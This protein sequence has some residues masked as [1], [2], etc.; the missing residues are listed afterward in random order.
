MFMKK[1]SLLIACMAFV[2]L[3]M[4]QLVPFD[5]L[6]LGQTPPGNE[7]KIFKLEVT[8]GKF[9][10]ERIAISKDGSEIY[11][12]EVKGYYPN[13]GEKTRYYKYTNN[14][15]SGSVVLFE[16]FSGPALSVTDDTLF[17]EREFKMYYSV[18]KNSGWS[19]PEVF[20]SAIDSAHYLQVT[21]K[22][23]YYA[24][25]RSK[26]SVG[27]SDWSKIQITGK[28]TIAVSLGFPV[29]RVVD[30]LDF[31]VAKDESYMITCP[32]GPIGISYPEKEEGKWS[33]MRYLNEKINFGIGGWGTY[34]TADNKY[35]FYTT[36][37]KMDY[38]DTYIYWVSMGNIVDSLKHTNRPPY[39]KNKPRVQSATVG[40]NFIYTLPVDAFCDDDGTIITQ[41]ALLIDGNPLPAWL[42]F[43]TESKTLSGTPPEIGKV[44]LRFNAY[45]D[46]KEVTAFRFIIDVANK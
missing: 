17:L 35:L 7:P 43:D 32:T 44:I 25:A 22:G 28:D 31:F 19:K 39:V 4:S 41:E 2:K 37:T 40:V 29:N 15:W 42:T 10:A 13:T 38:S 26:S 8:P 34:V 46:K 27:L 16:G 3:G 6:Y 5:S 1:I 20:Y 36:G 24:S 23:N 14:K 45:D 12:S 11:Y 9:A 21:N 18:R 30:D 33:N